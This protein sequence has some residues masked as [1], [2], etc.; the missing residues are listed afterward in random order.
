[1]PLAL[2]MNKR[3]GMAVIAIV[4]VV[5]LLGVLAVAIT[6][7]ADAWHSL[8]ASKKECIN[9]MKTVLG[10]TTREAQFMCNKVVP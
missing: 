3:V 4:A 8:F 6:Q 9:Y 1:M 5:G 2:T 10:N 7:T